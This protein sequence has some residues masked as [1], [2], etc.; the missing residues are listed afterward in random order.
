MGNGNS[1]KPLPDFF[2]CKGVAFN[3]CGCK[4]TFGQINFE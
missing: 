3:G 1:F 2:L 4:N